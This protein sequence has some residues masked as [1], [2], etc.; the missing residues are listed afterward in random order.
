MRQPMV[1]HQ[2]H[3]RW[4]RPSNTV[5]IISGGPKGFWSGWSKGL[6]G[7]NGHLAGNIATPER[8]LNFAGTTGGAV[9][10]I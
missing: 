1:R 3:T 10:S 8:T 2:A 5:S 6:S 4:E 9:E 7:Q